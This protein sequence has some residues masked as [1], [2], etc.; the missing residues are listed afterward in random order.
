M[1]PGS[2]E[3][4]YMNYNVPANIPVN[5]S[6]L[7][8]DSVAYKTPISNWLT[9]YSPWNNVNYFTT[10][11]VAAYDPNFKEVSPKGTGP[12]G[13]ITYADSTLEYMVHFQNTGSSAA[14][15]IIIV[16]TLDNNLNWTSLRPV[17]MSAPCKVTMQQ[18]ASYKIVKFT[19]NNINLPTQTS[20]PMGS[21]GMLTY[22]IKTN[23]GLPLGTQFRNHAS[24][25]F[26]YN[27]PVTT[28]TT[29]NTLGASS[30]TAVNNPSIEKTNSF[31]VYPN[32]ANKDFYAQVNSSAVASA[33]MYISDITGKILISKTITLQQGTQTI[34]TDV[35]QLAPGMYFVNLTQNGKIQTAKLVIMK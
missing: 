30:T 8:L 29:L 4:F 28:N 2:D 22:T 33:E 3:V 1:N 17:Y 32:P 34:S 23:S 26:D 5:T 6:V 31:T 16:D 10:T 11:T 14:Q 24:I 21:N 7:F 19:F 9:D 18:V 25:Y 15:N 12:T 13:L 20:S 27:A 35:T